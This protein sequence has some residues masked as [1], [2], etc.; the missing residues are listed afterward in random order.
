MSRRKVK[1]TVD[2][3]DS[4]D[5]FTSKKVKIKETVPETKTRREAPI[6]EIKAIPNRNGQR[7]TIDDYVVASEKSNND[8]VKKKNFLEKS[9]SE[10]PK[11]PRVDTESFIKKAELKHGT[12][13]YEYSSVK[14]LNAKSKVTIHC[15]RCNTSFEQTPNNHLSGYGCTTCGYKQNAE[16]QRMTLE[17]FIKKAHEA[18]GNS[19][20]D[21]SKVIYTNSQAKVWIHCNTCH[22]DFDQAPASH[23]QGIGCRFCAGK[24]KTTT[25]FILEAQE[26]HGLTRYDYSRVIYVNAASKVTI[27]C[28]VCDEYFEQTPNQH[29]GGHGCWDCG[30]KKSRDAQR[31]GKEEFV[32]RSRLRHCDRFD[33][34]E[35]EYLN[36]NTHV[37]IK[38]LECMKIFEQTPSHHSLGDGCP[39]CRYRRVSE[40]TNMGR[41]AFITKAQAIHG[42]D[43]FD[44][45]SVKYVNRTTRVLI[46]CVIC[47]TSFWQQA[48]SHISGNGCKTCKYIKHGDEQRMT[49]VEFLEVACQVHPKGAY[50]YSS[51]TFL[52]AN[53]PL[54]ITCNSCGNKFQQMASVHL[55]PSGCRDCAIQ[56][57]IV[58]MRMPQDEFILRSENLF[59]KGRYNY[60]KLDYKGMAEKVRI[61][62][63][64]CDC[65][66]EQLAG[67]HLAGH[68]G[69]HTC[70]KTKISY[71]EGLLFAT[72]QENN[73]SFLSQF[74]LPTLKRRYFDA[75]LLSKLYNNVIVEFDG[76]QHFQ[77]VPL[78]HKTL[79]GW[80]E[81]QTRDVTKTVAALQAGFRVV[82]IDYSLAGKTQLTKSKFKTAL[83]TLF[84]AKEQLCVSSG[85]LYATMITEVRK[86]V[87]DVTTFALASNSS[88]PTADE[89]EENQTSDAFEED[90]SIE[91][92]ENLFAIRDHVVLSLLTEIFESKQAILECILKCIE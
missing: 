14:Y 24:D 85:D 7:Q 79:F 17:E 19:T 13:L 9:I 12:D 67:N 2:M 64:S 53:D 76:G 40:Y 63:N 88:L 1:D 92:D 41:D 38:C 42:V 59:G 32:N 26:V 44:Y 52:S 62:C 6:A 23:L 87:T 10:K 46:R 18:H 37:K 4:K 83:Q 39:N 89:S 27:Q 36:A 45:S 71:G 69:C 55:R 22:K 15:L 28:Q 81:A 86:C 70:K 77:F 91:I 60:D 75:R 29:L 11:R 65:E 66:F 49:F 31:L 80:N 82:R 61:H 48:G 54:E 34:S 74:V 25:D 58:R 21:Y 3:A 30:V 73:I 72:L 33:Y 68:D 50:S 84:D 90:Y 20:F 16:K 56:K 78:F 47:N 51:D 43:L 5:D 8:H 35:V 57:A